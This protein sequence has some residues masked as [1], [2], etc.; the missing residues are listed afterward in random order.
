M[1][2]RFDRLPIRSAKRREESLTPIFFFPNH[3][4]NPRILTIQ[5][6]RLPIRSAKRREESL[7]PIFFFP[8][9][10]ENPKILTILIQTMEIPPFGLPIQGF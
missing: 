8:N 10:L 2:I 7:T 6:D 1:K 9:H 3:L 4:E 5:F